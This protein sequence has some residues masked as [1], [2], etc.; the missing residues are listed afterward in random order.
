[1]KRPMGNR[2][3]LLTALGVDNFGSGLFL[4][5]SLVYA[6]RVVGLPVATAGTVISV[7]TLAGLAV[8]PLAGRL[9]D[10]IGPRV[11]VI[12]AQL[13]QALGAVAYLLAHGVTVILLAAVLL[14][15]GQQLFY[16]S[17]SSLISEVAGDSPR[18]R[19]FAVA[20]MVRGAC[21]GFGA[22]VVGGIL[23]SAGPTGYRVAVAGDGGSFVACSLLLALF[24]RIPRQQRNGG[25]AVKGGSKP[26]LSDQP[27]LAL[28]AVTGMITLATD[29]FLIGMP[30]YVLMQLHAQPWLPGAILVLLT[31]LS[32]VGG[33]AALNATRHLSRITAMQVAGALYVVWCAASLAAVVVPSRWRPAELLAATVILAIAGLL[34]MPRALALAEA[35]APPA[36]RGR[37]L[38]AFQY[39][40]TV[41][42]VV[43]P[44][45]VALFS[46]AVW[47]P[48]LLVAAS[49]G[50]AILALRSLAGYLPPGALR[51]KTRVWR[52][53]ARSGVAV[54]AVGAPQVR[55][56]YLAT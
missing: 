8:P 10:R 43:A 9:V 2:L 42:G 55:E 38:A 4:P 56:G 16:G 54:D 35:A 37:Y 3:A 47:L 31:V 24:V 15:A 41:A 40:F 30:V 5:L 25:T 13:L 33:I 28:I 7:G 53:L 26:L 32:S 45:A 6:T 49:A 22:L 46:V 48:W 52:K 29:F 44:A 51:P 20:N 27:F 36:V 17:L 14:A 1:M 50:F 19:P 18:D 34:F 12:A 11:V 21:F 39:A 23:A